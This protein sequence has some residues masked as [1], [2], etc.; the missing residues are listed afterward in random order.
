MSKVQKAIRNKRFQVKAGASVKLVIDTNIGERVELAVSDCSAN[1]LGSDCNLSGR[2]CE[3]MN[4]GDIIS[5][6]KLTWESKEV[7][8]G[9]LV[10]RR[11]IDKGSGVFYLAFSTV[12][13]KVPVGESLSKL[14]VINLDRSDMIDDREL[15]SERFNLSNFVEN[16]FTNVDLFAR[17]RDFSVFHRD[18]EQSQKYAYQNFRS[19]S[20]G[21][22][23]NLKRP[24]KDG[25]TDYIM[26]GSNDYLGLGAHPEVIEAAK[27]ALDLYGFG[28]T[29]SPVSTGL[30]D[31]HFD[32][33]EK[34]ARIHQKESAILFNSGYAAN[35]GIIAALCSVNDLVI[36]DQL[37][38][39][40][41]QDGMQMAK[42]TSRF[43]KHN[44][45]QHLRDVL[46]K[47]RG[48]FNGCLIV[49]EGVFS[50][51]GDV[52]RLD[53][54]FQ[55]AR[56]FNCRVMV[57]QAHDWGVLGPNGMGVCDKFGLLRDVDIIMGTFSKIGG[58]IGGF[59]VASKEVIDWLR[60]FA[61][62]HL[63]S[64]SLPPSTVAAASK[65]ID[66]FLTDRS[67]F[68]KLRENIRHFCKAL[69]A[70]GCPVPESHESA[71]IPIIIGDESKMGAMYQSLLND[72][73]WCVPVVYPVVSRRNC[74]FRFTIM[75]TH[76]VTDLDYAVICLEKAALKTNFSFNV[77]EA[78]IKRTG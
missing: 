75:A 60:Y 34:L 4:V 42:A 55:V 32:L 45:V 66:L 6:A 52:S 1:G 5:A 50:M 8:L 77:P 28:A 53:E 59:A 62:P 10:I 54:I 49:T 33:C 24:R 68:E 65:A 13:I 9:R 36:A 46:E 58:S 44:N 23:I 69:R 2:S 47:E 37:C 57:D 78:E 48:N 11:V 22:R 70:I 64:V 7:S 31:L 74:R 15:S 67:H 71:V 41:I 40:S 27:K 29:G 30:S 76:S 17:V 63:F 14:L 20:K 19:A 25:R 72:G 18:W 12:D 43:F 38:H 56:D 39:A 16:E 51:D 73:I 21:S 26:M 61:R 35:V 3:W